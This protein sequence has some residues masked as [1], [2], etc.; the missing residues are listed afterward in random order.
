MNTPAALQPAADALA[1]GDYAAARTLAVDAI[2]QDAAGRDASHP[3]DS[4]RAA[5][6]RL[7][8]RS[9]FEAGDFAR[10]QAAYAEVTARLPLPEDELNL[11]LAA[12]RAGDLDAGQ[13]AFARAVADNE[14]HA[15]MDAP[16]IPQMT[17]AYAEA[18]RAV[19]EPTRAA[20][21]VTQL[22]EAYGALTI[23]DEGFLQ[24]RGVPA[25]ADFLA[26]ARRVLP[27]AQGGDGPAVLAALR[28]RVDEA[29]R[30]AIDA[31]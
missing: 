6:E 16:T 2:R 14:R 18:L 1:R 27:H 12:T 10:A 13:V 21:Q 5:A 17:F 29:G 25:F 28:A 8:A 22:A 3:D 7:V 23:T 4:L 31:G 9:Y 24:L 15:T 30:A 26:L 20:A 19:G 11:A